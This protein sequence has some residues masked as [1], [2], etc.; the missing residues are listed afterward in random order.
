MVNQGIYTDTVW[1]FG[2]QF[3]DVNGS[4]LAL[5][6]NYEC[7]VYRKDDLAAP[8]FTFSYSDGTIDEAD[9]GVG[10]LR[11][12]A[13]PTQHQP[14]VPAGTYRL[15][16]KRVDSADLWMAE[17]E[18]VVARPGELQN[19]IRFGE[20]TD[21]STASAYVV[22]V[23]SEI[24][25]ENFLRVPA[26]ESV[27]ELPVSASRANKFLKFD[28]TGQPVVADVTTSDISAVLFGAAQTLTDAQ[29]LT[30]KGNI[31]LVEETAS[32]LS[33]YLLSGTAILATAVNTVT[34]KLTV[35]ETHGFC[36]GFPVYV[37]VTSGSAIAD[38]IYYVIYDPQTFATNEIKLAT[39]FD[40][41]MDGIAMPLSSGTLPSMRLHRD[42]L[43]RI[44]DT[45]GR[46]KDGTEGGVIIGPLTG[47]VTPK[48]F[49]ADV[50]V[51]D[52]SE[53][54]QMA[55]H[56]VRTSRLGTPAKWASSLDGQNVAYRV[57]RSINMTGIS[58]PDA[59][60]QNMHIY[61]EADG[62]A[63]LDLTGSNNLNL[64]G[65][66][67]VG[68]A[69]LTPDV[70]ILGQRRLVPLLGG[71]FSTAQPEAGSHLLTGG[72]ISGSYRKSTYMLINTD[73]LR[74]SD[75][76]FA[77]DYNSTVAKVG[78]ICTDPDA[79]VRHFGSLTKSLYRPSPDETYTAADI[80]TI[81]KAVFRNTQHRARANYQLFPTAIDTSATP[82]VFTFGAGL[83][84]AAGVT[85][86]VPV[87]FLVG[88]NGWTL[89]RGAYW[90][91]NVTSTTAELWSEDG[92]AA[93]SHLT[94]S[95]TGGLV[96]GTYTS[97]SGRITARKS[98]PVTICGPL[99]EIEIDG[100][101]L[102]YETSAID[103]DLTDGNIH[104][105]RLRVHCESADLR[106][107][108]LL[109]YS[110]AARKLTAALLHVSGDL[111]GYGHVYKPFGQAPITIDGDIELSSNQSG[112]QP[113]ISNYGAR[114]FAGDLAN[115]SV[116]GRVRTTLSDF[117]LNLDDIGVADLD[118]YDE[119]T[120][121]RTKY[122]VAHYETFTSRN[123][124]MSAD[125][126]L[127]GSYAGVANRVD[128]MP[129]IM[130]RTVTVDSVSVSVSVGVAAAQGKIIVYKSDRRGRPSKLMTESVALDFSTADVKTHAVTLTFIGG[131]RYWF[132][133]R[134]SSTA[135]VRA[136]PENAS[137]TLASAAT[138]TNNPAKMLQ[139]TLTFATDAPSTWGWTHTEEVV[140][141]VPAIWA[142]EL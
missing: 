33:S 34:A 135:T 117:I 67:I 141:P 9:K 111:V 109:N 68:D 71:G 97:G 70:G 101:F 98:T 23:G 122:P 73:L 113:I 121:V 16:L 26:L 36:T 112:T 94:A 35:P 72:Y 78:F 127:L 142:S 136:L 130:P 80:G 120:G 64:F 76:T 88:N 74:F 45:T 59:V 27:D 108:N 43:K 6:G 118:I 114:M 95:H 41:A 25:P 69:T 133:V 107:W 83:L 86:D 28:A 125:A 62:V 138:P 50:D 18:M 77:N 134:H 124:L 116:Y 52:N 140:G 42:P 100:Y 47:Q 32:D 15:H 129:F 56:W 115:L 139:R 102:G 131:A 61:S 55:I 37:A 19:Y 7:E 51:A 58:Q 75:Q 91:K 38:T 11:L 53:A 66:R 17:G 123:M 60:F 13:N 110:G 40:N 54:Y 65:L 12:N 92:T 85:G 126:G 44:V 84:A 31:G 22:A 30:A 81:T 20:A 105:L 46:K 1:T 93:V 21:G 2:V 99:D 87:T 79:V 5:P 90:L 3:N 82:I 104:G 106:T 119:E 137:P 49:G 29:V 4:P 10:V 39:S 89:R 103:I 96:A 48:I 57:S 128:L 8:V 14:D 132:G 24:V 63:A